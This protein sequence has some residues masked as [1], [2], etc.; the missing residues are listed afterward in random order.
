MAADVTVPD[1]LKQT[2]KLKL[3]STVSRVAARGACFVSSAALLLRCGVRLCWWVNVPRRDGITAMTNHAL[4]LRLGARLLGG[5]VGNRQLS[6]CW[7]VICPHVVWP[8][9]TAAELEF[10]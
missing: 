6:C 3:L 4:P 10:I 7:C 8:V 9:S 2:E 1:L 5:G